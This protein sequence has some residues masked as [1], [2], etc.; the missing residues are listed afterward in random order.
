[1][2][3]QNKAGHKEVKCLRNSGIKEKKK[4]TYSEKKK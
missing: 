3:S 1:M 4:E 2:E